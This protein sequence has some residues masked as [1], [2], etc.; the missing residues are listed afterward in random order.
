MTPPDSVVLRSRETV[1][2][3]ILFEVPNIFYE[4]V[5]F[6]VCNMG[7]SKN[8]GTPKWMVKIME[9]PIKMDDLGWKPPI[10]GN[11]HIGQ[12]C[13]RKSL[14]HWAGLNGA[15]FWGVKKFCFSEK[16]LQGICWVKTKK[17]VCWDMMRNPKRS[18]FFSIVLI[19]L[20]SQ[21]K[22]QCSADLQFLI[23]ESVMM[24]FF[25]QRKMAIRSCRSLRYYS[26]SLRKGP[27]RSKNTKIPS[28]TGVNYFFFSWYSWTKS[29]SCDDFPLHLHTFTVYLQ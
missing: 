16:A 13:C 22:K 12:I 2:T 5:V 3:R 14:A 23:T 26:F 10:F 11:I 8:R 4:S 27:Q 25:V 6:F 9:N 17:H 1:S 15:R 20:R 21:N 19:L 24:D 29:V 18:R 28:W 7:V